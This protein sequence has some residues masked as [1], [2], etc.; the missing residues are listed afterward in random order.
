MSV[1]ASNEDEEDFISS[2][3]L[4]WDQFPTRRALLATLDAVCAALGAPGTML[5]CKMLNRLWELASCVPAGAAHVLNCVN[6]ARVKSKE[7]GPENEA[8]LN[9]VEDISLREA[10][11]S[12]YFK[13]RGVTERGTKSVQ[14]TTPKSLDWIPLAT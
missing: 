9:M 13:V 8:F 11:K 6:L 14:H 7:G 5:V 10:K 4:L 12:P 2:A 1:Y 3:T